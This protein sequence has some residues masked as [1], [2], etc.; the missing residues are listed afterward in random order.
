[1]QGERENKHVTGKG[2]DRCERQ[3]GGDIKWN[4]GAWSATGL[5]IG[6]G[7]ELHRGSELGSL[8]PQYRCTPDIKVAGE[9][10]V[11]QYCVLTYQKW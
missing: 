8:K 9:S 11:C 5:P 3:M 2:E 4:E 1:M 10:L 6:S 7:L